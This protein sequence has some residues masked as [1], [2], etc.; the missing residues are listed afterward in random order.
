MGG[1]PAVV[2]EHGDAPVGMGTTVSAE[3]GLNS[4]VRSSVDFQGLSPYQKWELGNIVR[5][6]ANGTVSAY[7]W[8]RLGDIHRDKPAAC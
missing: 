6:R 4:I 2:T 7:A 8:A 5:G 1:I 3:G